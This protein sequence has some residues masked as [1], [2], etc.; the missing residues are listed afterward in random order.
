VAS[1]LDPGHEEGITG[2]KES[3]PI[4]KRNRQDRLLYRGLAD[5]V[6]ST[7]K[8]TDD[9]IKNTFVIG[10][11]WVILSSFSA[12]AYSL[13]PEKNI[14]RVFDVVNQAIH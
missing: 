7:H 12:I 9:K 3:L 1:P 14:S 8:K 2:G 5:R 11:S 13:I 10:V 6:M 4:L